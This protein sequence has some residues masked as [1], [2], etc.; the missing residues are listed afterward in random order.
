MLNRLTKQWKKDGTDIQLLKFQ[1]IGVSDKNKSNIC[2]RRY[3]KWKYNTDIYYK[4][5]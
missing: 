5:D 4:I 1:Y 3:S 2:L